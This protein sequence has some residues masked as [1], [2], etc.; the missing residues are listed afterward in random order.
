MGHKTPNDAHAHVEDNHG[1]IVDSKLLPSPAG[2]MVYGVVEFVP[3]QEP[4][5]NPSVL[6]TK[7]IAQA[8]AE[9][10]WLMWKGDS[11]VIFSP[12]ELEK[13]QASGVFCHGDDNFTLIDP[14]DLLSGVEKRIEQ[15]QKE[16]DSLR[17]R[18]GLQPGEEPVKK[19]LLSS[20]YGK[21]GKF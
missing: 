17:A 12:D 4:K 13:T 9:G 14:K 8:R 3:H 21:F 16:R 11:S 18:M 10:K 15:A 5:M 1:K 19:L 7:K 6:S 2:E 20:E